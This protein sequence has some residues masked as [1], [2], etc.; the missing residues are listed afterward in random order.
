VI[1][2]VRRLFGLR[3]AKAAV[4]EDEAAVGGGKSR[5]RG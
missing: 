3:D 5:T 4:R 2:L 1:D